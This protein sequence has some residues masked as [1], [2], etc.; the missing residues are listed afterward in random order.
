MTLTPRQL[1]A[2][3]VIAE[4]ETISAAA[5]SCGVNRATL[6]RWQALPEF[7]AALDELQAEA[8]A[9][10][11]RRLSLALDRAAQHVIHL[12][13]SAEDEAV[14]L[15]AAMAVPQMLREVLELEH[16]AAP[17]AITIE[18]EFAAPRTVF[19]HGAA[20]ASLMRGASS[21]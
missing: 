16:A 17:A 5:Q 18:S 1:R 21:E 9:R 20:V 13:D 15:R 6:H 10:A 7:R 19:D 4:S 11:V 3:Q 14:R 12:A 2:V 8:R